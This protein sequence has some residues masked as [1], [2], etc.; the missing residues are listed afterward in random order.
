MSVP[1]FF[2]L[3]VERWVI[4]SVVHAGNPTLPQVVQ[5]VNTA[6]KYSAYHTHKDLGLLRG[7]RTGGICGTAGHAGHRRGDSEWTSATFTVSYEA[8]HTRP[9]KPQDPLVFVA[10]GILEMLRP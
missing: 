7:K 1:E 10:V 6:I 9:N 3:M 5:N 8:K 4:S 2:R